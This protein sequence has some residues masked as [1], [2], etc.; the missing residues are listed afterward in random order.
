MK[1]R[2]STCAPTMEGREKKFEFS[3]HQPTDAKIKELSVTSI[4]CSSS[5]LGA[6]QI[7]RVLI[8]LLGWTILEM[9]IDMNLE[10][11]TNFTNS[12][13]PAPVASKCPTN[14]TAVGDRVK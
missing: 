1:R 11:F 9:R 2:R 13:N 3:H 7:Q 5:K 6:T 10:A 4:E 12:K 8:R 14:V